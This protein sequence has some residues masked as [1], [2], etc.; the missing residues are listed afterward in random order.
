MESMRGGY[1]TLSLGYPKSAQQVPR[2]CQKT[3]IELLSPTKR[4]APNPLD[5]NPEALPHMPLLDLEM[6]ITFW[7]LDLKNGA[8]ISETQS[9]DSVNSLWLQVSALPQTNTG[10]SQRPPASV[11]S[12][13]ES[14]Q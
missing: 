5:P 7:N 2:T 9:S 13:L 1:P 6:V 14:G 4:I 11:C 3:R 12:E 8:Q 10:T